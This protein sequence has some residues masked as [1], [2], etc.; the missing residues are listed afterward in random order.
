MTRVLHRYGFTQG[1][2]VTGH[3]GA[4][5]VPNLGM[6]VKTIPLT[7]VSWVLMVLQLI[8]WVHRLHFNFEGIVG[9]AG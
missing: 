8:R 6:C 3:V 9:V 4:G 2:W 7:M 1:F 5:T